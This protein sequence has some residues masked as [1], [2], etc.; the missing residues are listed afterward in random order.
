MHMLPP[1]PICYHS[2]GRTNIQ[3]DQ[4]SFDLFALM[5]LYRNS[6]PSST[7]ILR[8]LDYYYIIILIV[9]YFGPKM[10]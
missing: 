1:S 7:L 4:C 2:V 9:H 3:N 6:I 5:M 10:I 8:Y